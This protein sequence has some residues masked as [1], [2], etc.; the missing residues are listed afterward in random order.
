MVCMHVCCVCARVFARVYPCK[1]SPNPHQLLLQVEGQCSLEE[2][3][4]E[5]IFSALNDTMDQTGMGHWVINKSVSRSRTQ[6]ART[7][8]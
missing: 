8:N 1:T 7:W 4:T 6:Q 5:E 2:S 3:K